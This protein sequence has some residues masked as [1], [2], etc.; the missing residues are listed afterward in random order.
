MSNELEIININEDNVEIFKKDNHIKIISN[1][2]SRNKEQI[3]DLFRNKKIFKY[4]YKQ[5]I[6]LIKEFHINGK[7]TKIIYVFTDELNINGGNFDYICLK[8]NVN[9]I[10]SNNIIIEGIKD[11]KFIELNKNYNKMEIDY[12]NIEIKNNKD[13][14]II[15]T[16]FKFCKDKIPD[17]LGKKLAKII[18]KIM[19]RL[20]KSLE[21]L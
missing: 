4:I 20:C 6:D 1:F 12:L 10:D 11:S 7:L 15:E 14:I 2:N 13:K 17:F 16:N 8:I 21:N 5:N 19:A 18:G 9:L 3:F